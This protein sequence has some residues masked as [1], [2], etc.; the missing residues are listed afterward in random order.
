MHNPFDRNWKEEFEPI[1]KPEEKTQELEEKAYADITVIFDRSGSMYK[2]KNAVIEG[3]NTFI[4]KMRATPGD[5]RWTL[6]QFDDVDN[7]ICANEKFPQVVFENKNEK[8]IEFLKDT[9]YTPRGGTA[10]IDAVSLTI[11]RVEE[12]IRGKEDKIKPIVMIV[13]DGQENKIG[14]A[15][16]RERV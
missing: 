14:R 10:L 2:M 11:N 6:V 13:T 4:C 16:C 12:R 5:N 8:E 7:A 15:S 1:Q 9:D 3:F